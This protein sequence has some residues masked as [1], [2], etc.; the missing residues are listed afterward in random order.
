MS[1]HSNYVPK[2]AFGRWF[3][4]RL[5]IM[6][7]IHSSFVVF[8]NPR[9]LNYYWTFGGILAFMLVSQILTGVVLAMHYAANVDLA[10]NSVEQIMR[11]VN[12]GWMLRYLHANGAS[13]FFVAV[14]VHI[15]RGLYYG[16]YKEPREVLWILG[17]IIFLLMM[18]TA[19]MGY[20]LPWGQMSFWG[21]TVITN[22]FSALPGVGETIV[23][24][25]WG[26]YSVGNSTLNRFFSLHYLLPFMIFG[27]VALHVWA[28]HVPGSNNPAGIEKKTDKDTLPFH[29]YFTIKDAFAV[30]CFVIFF[31]WFTF[32]IP[33]Y[34]GHADN[35]I[36]ANPAVT[37]AHIVPEWYFLPFYA[38]LRAVPDKLLG[39][40]AMFGS[41]AILVFLPWLDTSKVRSGAYRPAFRVFFWMFI[42]NA[43]VLGWLGAKPPEGLYVIASRLCTA[44]YFA[45][46]IVILPLLGKIERTLPVPASIAEAVL[47]PSGSGSAMAAGAASSP[48]SQG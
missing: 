46:F 11:D 37:P 42:A 14:Y 8:P 7:L 29:P 4:R 41:I 1:G 22:L 6:G 24:Y 12:Y 28:L 40:L 5:P 16:S 30:V 27:V 13:M 9:N 25:L 3:E 48:N 2:S 45:Y 33:N 36:E 17:V 15:G 26:G 47:G 18:A 23:T 38:I 31:S 44:Y 19:F 10:F 43:I 21:A 35:Y 20:V 39:V 34:L 32:Y